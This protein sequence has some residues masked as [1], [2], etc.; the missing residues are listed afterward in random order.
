MLFGKSDKKEGFFSKLKAAVT[1]TKANLVAKIEDVVKGRKEIDA[2]LLDELEAIL[3]GADIGVE[4]TSEILEKIKE[5]VDRKQIND[6]DQL[7]SLIKQEL[8]Q[9]LEKA[10]TTNLEGVRPDL[11]VIMVVGVN[12]VGKTT[13]IGKLANLYQSEGQRVLI[14]AADTFRAAAIEQ[15][16][17]WG[18]RAGVEII[19]QKSGAD[20]SAVLFDS[21]SAAKARQVQT[22]IVDTAGRLHTKDN[23][24]RELEKMKRIASREVP[25]A[26]HEVL[27]II[28]AITGQNGLNQAREFLKSAGV[29]GIV[30]TKLDGT[31]KGGVVIPI[32]RELK[33]PIQFVGVGEKID[34]L[35]RFSPE[36]YIESLFEA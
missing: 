34:D 30:L 10:V 11:Q 1:S 29:T 20:P 21:I 3:I 31:A 13:T 28:D 8:R 18:Q 4:T 5:Q 24:M 25:G 35:L 32:A 12:G 36:Q 7:K 27:L 22:L 9:I 2:D 26:P 17:V 16:E 19:R 14:C 33:V 6:A 15:L 23:L